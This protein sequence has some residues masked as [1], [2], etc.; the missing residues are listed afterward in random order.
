MHFFTTHFHHFNLYCG[1]VGLFY[2]QLEG[3]AS[4]WDKAAE[5]T[6]HSMGNYGLM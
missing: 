3:M 5:T 2:E 6:S 1:Q 4:G